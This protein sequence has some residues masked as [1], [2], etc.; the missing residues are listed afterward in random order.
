MRIEVAGG[1]RSREAVD[2]ALTKGAYRVVI[3]TAALTN[4][5]LVADLVAADGSD[6]VVIA[7]D[8][9]DGLAVGEGW[10]ESA[11]GKRPENILLELA[12]VGARWFAVTAIERDGRLEGPDLR[13]LRRL[14]SLGAGRIIAS[15]GIASIDDLMAVREAGC[16]GAIVG[17]AIYEGRVDLRRALAAVPAS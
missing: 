1:L 17:R 15:G 14:I 12:S 6:A 4:T 16:A 13:L 7:I 5:A 8:V 2:R 9:R 3:G 10:H 11:A